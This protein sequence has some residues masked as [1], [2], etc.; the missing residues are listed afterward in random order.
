MACGQTEEVGGRKKG[1]GPIVATQS[2][3][4]RHGAE[5]GG[6]IG[7]MG[8]ATFLELRALVRA[9]LGNELVPLADAR[10]VNRC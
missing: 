10:C 2:A 6:R 3:L 9:S 5:G 1:G 4:Y 7:R 8:N